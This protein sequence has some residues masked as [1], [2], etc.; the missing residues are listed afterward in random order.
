MA[1][2]T[3]K[4]S[5][6]RLRLL[7]Y[8]RYRQR[9]VYAEVVVLGEV[10]AADGATVE[11]QLIWSRTN[12]VVGEKTLSRLLSRQRT[13]VQFDIGDVGSGMCFYRA[14]LIDR[15]GI[16][17]PMEVLHEKSRGRT[18]WLGTRTGISR[19][20]PAPWT[21]LQSVKKRERL[22][23]SCWG[24]EY[25][26]DRKH[27]VT[28][29]TA[30]E[31]SLLAAPMRLVATLKGRRVR[32]KADSFSVLSR[33]KDQVVFAARYASG[34]LQVD[35][36]SY[37][38]FDGMIRVDW[39]LSSRRPV[40]I[41]G[42]VLEIPIRA[43]HAKYFYHFPG[44]WYSA[45]NVGALP[46]KGLLLPF[47]PFVWLGDEQRGLAWFAESD[48][49]W[50]NRDPRR[51]T[52]IKREGQ[53]VNLRI[54]LLSSPVKL[55]PAGKDAA[56]VTGFGQESAVA[57]TVAELKYSFGLQATPVKPVVKDAWDHRIV[58]I[59]QDTPG[60]VTRLDVRTSLLDRLAKAGVR[61][62]V[63]FEHW[64][65]AE[66]HPKTPHVARLK[67]IVQA[68]HARGLK[69]LLYF[70]FLISDIAPEWEAIGK[71]AIVAPKRGYPV[72][73]YLPQPEQSS[74]C[75][76]LA[77]IW[78][79][80]LVSGMAET[81]K[82]F[83]VDG[84]YLDGT[85][86]PSGC[87]NTEHGC[88]HLRDDGSI[89]PTYP[90]FSVR[91]AMRRIYEVVRSHRPDGQLNVHNS[92]CMTI[93]TLGWGTSYWDGEQFGQFGTGDSPSADSVDP[94]KL[95]PLDAFRAEFMGHQ[96]GVPAEFLCYGKPFSFEQ[97]WSFTLLHDVPVRP[98]ATHE[99]LALASSVWKAMDD[100]GR[101]KSEWIPYW[102]INKQIKITP[103]HVIASLYRHP[104]NGVLAVIS[105]FSRKAVRASIQI[106]L[107]SL[108]FKA[109]PQ[110]VKDALSGKDIPLDRNRMRFSLA[111][112]GWKLVWLK[113]S[114]AKIPRRVRLP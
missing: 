13:E 1:I 16:R 23:V 71:D 113:P 4:L 78:Q 90:I 65:D 64:A 32:W 101:K 42:L 31:A 73:H 22:K 43:Q 7:V 6:R 20:V 35:A 106:D 12:E 75:V 27:F 61:T 49:N 47:R 112:M 83:D 14:T 79:D 38:D 68:C 95:L 85:E 91:S 46:A 53:A 58:C 88:G 63:I 102:K 108:G 8:T 99:E 59:T 104:K 29:I 87:C 28:K 60:F 41:D 93:P 76:C 109:Q 52:E 10:H 36:I 114:R 77:S 84:V 110:S 81:L 105:N 48:R 74:W 26:F 17:V 72:F 25:E 69:V 94:I 40:N 3:R 62:V 82:Q 30:N 39:T 56:H 15:Y 98:H 70:S 80:R 21:P 57:T 67:K 33:E 2:R 45:A 96:W 100:F 44:Q 86:Y 107:E 89:A 11:L 66:G 5:A 19:K 37:V 97:S 54:R 103:A 111:A 55:V 92:T 18:A 24:R 34:S 9:T 50:F 51:V